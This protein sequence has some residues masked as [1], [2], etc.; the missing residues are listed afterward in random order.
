MPDHTSPKRKR[1]QHQEQARPRLRFGLVS[2]LL[3]AVGWRTGSMRALLFGGAV[4]ASFLLSRWMTAHGAEEV[5]SS[6]GARGAENGAVYQPAGAPADP[7]V[8]A[9]WNYYRDYGQATELLKDLV[10][11]HPKLC[12]LESLGK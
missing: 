9:R 10:A 11:A 4:M 2:L 8:A 1:G 7:K 3:T 12:R 5:D 6:Q